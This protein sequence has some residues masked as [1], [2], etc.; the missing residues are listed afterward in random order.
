MLKKE[1]MCVNRSHVHS[2]Q[3]LYQRKLLRFSR[4]VNFV[5]LFYKSACKPFDLKPFYQYVND[6]EDDWN[7]RILRL[8]SR[9]SLSSLLLVRHPLLYYEPVTPSYNYSHRTPEYWNHDTTSPTNVDRTLP[10]IPEYTL[11]NNKISLKFKM[12][13]RNQSRCA[14]VRPNDKC[15]I[16][17]TQWITDRYDQFV[18]SPKTESHLQSHPDFFMKFNRC[19]S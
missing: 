6:I 14:D 5:S 7:M 15:L 10:R 12:N 8:N 4:C 2:V 9:L 19:F 11:Q 17:L 16:K 3:W 13:N 1:V 18:I